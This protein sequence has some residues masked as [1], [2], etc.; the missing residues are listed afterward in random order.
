MFGW[1]TRKAP[2]P[3]VFSDNLEAFAYAC[4]RAEN[5][6]LVNA[7]IPALIEERGRTG[8]EGERYFRLRLA[9]DTGEKRVWACTLKEATD[10]PEIG[11]FVGFR[12]VKIAS[13]L[14]AD[15]NL[16]GYVACKLR[17]EYVKSKGWRIASSYTPAD[18][19]P[20][21]HM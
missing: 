20:E 16:I 3:L 17:P 14:P 7:L 19:K 5:R 11:E 12:V 1:F 4:G 21:L 18:I 10:F 13:D 2:E 15:V 9:T 8:E 6:L